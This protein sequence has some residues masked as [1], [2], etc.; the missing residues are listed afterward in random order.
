[1]PRAAN[2]NADGLIFTRVRTAVATK[3]AAIGEA[4]GRASVSIGSCVGREKAMRAR[5][6]AV[7]PRPIAAKLSI[8]PRK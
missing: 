8:K 5:N 1:M 3:A 6:A 2:D 7:I 4:T